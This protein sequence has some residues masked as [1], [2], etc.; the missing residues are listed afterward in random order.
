ML[1][2]LLKIMITLLK[3]TYTNAFDVMHL[4]SWQQLVFAP[5]ESNALCG[6]HLGVQYSSTPHRL[7]TC[8]LHE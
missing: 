6:L 1:V 5:M 8:T 4:G 3:M 7:V 2:E